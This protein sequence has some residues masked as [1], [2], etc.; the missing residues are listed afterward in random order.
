MSKGDTLG[1]MNALRNQI[2]AGAVVGCLLTP[3]SGHTVPAVLRSYIEPTQEVNLPPSSPASY[4]PWYALPSR[5]L[6]SGGYF[7]K[8]SVTELQIDHVADNSR[9]TRKNR[10]FMISASFEQPVG[11]EFFSS[12]VDLPLVSADRFSVSRLAPA[13]VGDYVLFLSNTQLDN[14]AAYIRLSARF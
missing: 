4:M 3:V 11:R 5:F 2:L 9:C 12:R 13:S 1:G 8:L 7:M 10:T 6:F 14:P